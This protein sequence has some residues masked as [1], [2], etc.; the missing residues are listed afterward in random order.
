MSV[1]L[2]CCY[3]KSS[4]FFTLSIVTITSSL[5]CKRSNWPRRQSPFV[6]PTP[7]FASPIHS[8]T[9]QHRF[10]RPSRYL[11]TQSSIHRIA[12]LSDVSKA[13]RGDAQAHHIHSV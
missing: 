1:S 2:M 11:N 8:I 7:T 4:I 5:R 10:T 13:V 6:A 12:A 9:P 3:S